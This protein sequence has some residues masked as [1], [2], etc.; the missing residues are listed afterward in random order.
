MRDIDDLLRDDAQRWQARS[1]EPPDF[2]AALDAAVAAPAPGRRNVRL[3]L[4]VAATVVLVVGAVALALHLGHTSSNRSHQQGPASIVVNGKRIP[5]AGVVPWAGPISY[6]SDRSVVYVYADN[7]S[8]A[9]SNVCGVEADRAQV[10]ETSATVSITVVGYSRPLPEG[11]SC[12]APGHAPVPV[13]VHLGQPLDGRPLVDGS[14]GTSHRLL[15]AS[16]VPLPRSV[17][18][19]LVAL[20]LR[21]DDR[22]GIASRLWLPKKGSL[23]RCSI[24]VDYGPRRNIYQDMGAP[25]GVPGTATIGPTTANTWRDDKTGIHVITFEWAPRPGFVLRLEVASDNPSHPFSEEQELA[26]ARSVH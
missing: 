22:R 2:K 20:P 19:V 18:D 17:P 16:T 21:W 7:D 10:A 9:N 24:S 14:D 11:V 13:S 5:Y 23:C 8:I 26:I 15:D 6:A 12:A 1:P 4:S 25:T 3:L